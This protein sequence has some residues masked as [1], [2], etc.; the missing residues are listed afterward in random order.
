MKARSPSTILVYIIGSLGDTVITLPS[1]IALR[2]YFGQKTKIYL[3]FDKQPYSRVTP[4][5]L[6][7]DSHLVDG[8]INYEFK[9]SLLGRGRSLILLWWRIVKHRFDVVV[10]LIPSERSFISVYRDKLFFVLC[11]IPRRLGFHVFDKKILY[12]RD[13]FNRPSFVTHESIF[14]LERLRLSGIGISEYSDLSKISLF[15]PSPKLDNIRNLFFSKLKYPDR[16]LVAICPGSEMPSKQWPIERFMEIGRRLLEQEK[17]EIIII[18]GSGEYKNG[19]LLVDDWNDGINMTGSLSVRESVS[20]LQLCA[21]SVGLDSGATHLAALVGIPCVAIYSQRDYP[22]RWYPLGN[23]YVI[24][25]HALACA[26][27]LKKICPI[28]GHPCMNNITSNEVWQ[29]I[30]KITSQIK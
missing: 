3:L 19:Q 7:E 2:E 18:G 1:L 12:P 8:F 10:Y 13:K 9:K 21:F 5:Q 15:L 26:G 30:I 16:Y 24:V 20:V 14:R 11:F 29:A 28:Q 6:L 4:D 27:C 17:F 23:K 25:T 22:G